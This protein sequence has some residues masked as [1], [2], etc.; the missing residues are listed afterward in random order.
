MI[1]HRVK[2]FLSEIN[3]KIKDLGGW[4]L[5]IIIMVWG[6]IISWL[7]TRRP[8][9][10]EEESSWIGFVVLAI[11]VIG[12]YIYGKLSYLKKLEDIIRYLNDKYKLYRKIETYTK[13]GTIDGFL[14]PNNKDK[15][16][17]WPDSVEF[18]S[19]YTKAVLTSRKR[20][21]RRFRRESRFEPIV[22]QNLGK[23]AEKKVEDYKRKIEKKALL[24]DKRGG[25]DGNGATKI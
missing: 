10:Q 2:D 16:E 12:I 5:I 17:S 22:D 24:L 20:L 15:Q 21:Q 3:E 25:T 6:V 1:L 13:W 9:Y 4:T 7:D 14:K 18:Q 23:Y 19:N 11:F 8:D